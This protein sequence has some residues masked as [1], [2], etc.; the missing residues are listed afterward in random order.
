MTRIIQTHRGFVDK[1]IGDAIMAF[2]G[3][4]L[5][6]PAHPERACRAALAMIET[7]SGLN[8]SLRAQGY[9][10]LDI[11]VGINSGPAVV[12]NMGATERFNYTVIGDT[13]NLAS[14]LEGLNK[15]YGTHILI[16][17]HTRQGL[18][19]SF[20]TRYIEP[21]RVKGKAEPVGV[22]ELLANTPPHRDRVARFE[23]ARRQWREDREA[24]RQALARC[25][26]AGDSVAAAL[27][28]REAGEG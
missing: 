22:Y 7:L 2:W 18:G 12:G 14:R 25:A 9:P 4:P 1:Y 26:E 19:G 24:G 6:D 13:V 16:S 28:E 23:R 10:P 17:E 3:A 20:L 11:G 15:T 5:S 21:V 8:A 27:L